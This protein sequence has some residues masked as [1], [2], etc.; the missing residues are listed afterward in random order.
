VGKNP[1]FAEHYARAMEIRA[2]VNAE[3][4]IAYSHE[5]NAAVARSK[6]DAL[7]WHNEKMCGL[8]KYGRLVATENTL[9]VN[10]KPKLDFSAMP[11]E[12]RDQL[13]A[14]LTKQLNAPK[15]I[16]HDE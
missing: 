14:M 6:M 2:D 13:R 9:T 12:M 5:E 3:L 8:K 1:A 4:I 15:V 7:K 10:V 16:E 11:Q